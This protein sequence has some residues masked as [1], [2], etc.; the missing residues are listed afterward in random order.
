MKKFYFLVFI[1][2]FTLSCRSNAN[3]SIEPVLNPTV[4]SLAQVYLESQN[5]YNSLVATRSSMDVRRDL[6]TE[7]LD[8]LLILEKRIAIASSDVVNSWFD[9][10]LELRSDPNYT[11]ALKG[12][13]Y[14]K[15]GIVSLEYSYKK[16]SQI[17]DPTV[18]VHNKL[19]EI[20]HLEENCR[21]AISEIVGYSTTEYNTQ[22]IYK[23]IK[24]IYKSMR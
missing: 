9:F 18:E 21:V 1:L 16:K 10:Y 4:A 17:I 23:K 2:F 14:F 19:N 11:E 7:E 12:N 22:K 20:E 15:Q 6:T 24:K 8:Q 5:S 13:Y 3:W